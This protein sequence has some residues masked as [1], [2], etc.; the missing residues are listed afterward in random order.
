MKRLIALTAGL[1]ALAGAAHAQDIVRGGDPKAAIA[2]VVTVPAGYDT[3]YVSGMTPPVI[4]EKATGVAKF[5]DTKTQTLGVLGRIE[6][7]LKTQGATMADVV[8]MRVLLVGDPAKGGKMDFAGMM[9][10]YKTYFGTAT[11]PN[12]PARITSQITSLVQDGMLVEIEVQAAK[13]K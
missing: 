8:M 2:S 10:G 11:Q 9:E 3:I 1:C 13:K 12:K 6:A 5:G 7:A 4:D